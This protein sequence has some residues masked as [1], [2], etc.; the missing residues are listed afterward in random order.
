MCSHA[1][2]RRM[3]PHRPQQTRCL[4][5]LT[6]ASCPC[7]GAIARGASSCRLRHSLRPVLGNRHRRCQHS[8]R[9]HP[10]T[11]SP[12]TAG[13]ARY[14]PPAT[15]V[16]VKSPIRTARQRFH[17]FVVRAV[18]RHRKFQ[19]R[20]VAKIQAQTLTHWEMRGQI[21]RRHLL[22]VAPSRHRRHPNTSKTSP[23]WPTPWS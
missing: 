6:D 10:K 18:P 5:A 12:A 13:I 15:N 23:R 21:T 20:R 4:P 8:P 3:A 9:P 2:R 19:A 1:H 14:L 16:W 11:R 17:Y 22:Y 7:P